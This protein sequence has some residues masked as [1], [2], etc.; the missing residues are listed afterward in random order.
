MK[1]RKYSFFTLLELL[2][3][4]GIITVL[5]SMLL[6]GIQK[7]RE[8]AKQISCLSNNKQIGIAFL[9]Y[10]TDNNTWFPT[11]TMATSKP[12][13]SW[14]YQLSSYLNINWPS[15]N[16]FYPASGP[17]IFY[18]P[19]A[20]E[21]TIYASHVPSPKTLYYLSYGYNYAQ[22]ESRNDSGSWITVK[23]SKIKKPHSFLMSAD[24]EV[25]YA[26]NG[27]EEDKNNHS[28]AVGAQ[29]AWLN[30]FGYWHTSPYA[31]RHAGKLNI[32]FADGHA[33]ARKPRADGR[34]HDFYLVEEG[35][36]AA[37]YQ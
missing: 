17:S 36:V 4:I 12:Y 2:I 25:I 10:D 14:C 35:A 29:V 9:G 31:S 27:C 37:Y 8:Y 6:P 34:P 30:S 23:S 18:C 15:S 11:A 26:A 3:V 13:G 7:S 33:S 32:L 20:K 16:L 28:S 5:A 1:P 22:H 21:C 24:Y 19:A